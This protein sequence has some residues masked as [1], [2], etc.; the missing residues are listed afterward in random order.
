VLTQRDAIF[1]ALITSLCC[2]FVVS[3]FTAP[4]SAKQLTPFGE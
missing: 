1:P 4:P 3:L 2:L